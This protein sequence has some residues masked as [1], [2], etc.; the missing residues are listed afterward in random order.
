MIAARPDLLILGGLA[1]DRLADGSTV[2]GGSVVHGAR[3][4]AASGRR[5]ATIT[6]A[7]PEP[8]AVAAVEE[9]GRLGPCLHVPVSSS[10][11]YTIRDEGGQ[12]RL[13]Y[14][15][16]GALLA[17]MPA[18]VARIDPRAVLLAPIAGELGVDATLASV[19]V[20][21]RVGALQ[22]W[23]R[24]LSPGEQVAALPLDALGDGLSAAL[25][26][27]D[28]LVASNED[29]A[30]V[31]D[32][33][34]QQL[35]KLRDHFGAQ[36]IL[37]ITGGAAGAWLDGTP[38][39]ARWVPAARHIEGVSTLGAGDAVAALLAIALGDGLD[40]LAAIEAAIT[41]TAEFLASRA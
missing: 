13:I 8:E 28:A 15:G 19:T 7:G 4:A 30:G 22:G 9:L 37:A 3:A 14:E 29:L 39:G 10:I 6:A 23:L 1:I 34:R 33:P 12:R 17:V 5:V 24:S 16:G 40:P 2:A 31:A 25:A 38:V 20:P 11:C 18:D 36:P 35:A 21:V 41:G 32:H 27:L 26:E